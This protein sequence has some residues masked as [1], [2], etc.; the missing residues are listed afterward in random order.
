M[1]ATVSICSCVMAQAHAGEALPSQERVNSAYFFTIDGSFLKLR[2][3]D[4][5]LAADWKLSQTEGSSVLPPC[6]KTPVYAEP[7]CDLVFD[8]LQAGNGKLYGVF[9]TKAK[10]DD[11]GS[12]EYQVLV[13]QLPE[14]K[15][16]GSVPIPQAQ[17]EWPSLLL[18]PDGQRF[19]LN[20]RDR[21]AEKSATEPTVVSI[22]DVYGS[23]TLTK[24]S[25]MRQEV[26]T[27]VKRVAGGTLVHGFNLSVALLY[28]SYFSSDGST[29]FNGLRATKILGSS[30][31]ARNVN[32]LEKLSAEQREQLKPF[33]TIEPGTK[34]PYFN[35]GAADSA[36]G[37]TGVAV[38]NAAR[39]EAA[40]WTVDLVTSQVSPIVIAPWGVARLTPD[41]TV[42]VIQ[43]SE[44]QTSGGGNVPGTLLGA[45]FWLYD[46]ASG[47]KVGEF[48]DP[49]LAGPFS[50]NRLLCFSSDGKRFFYAVND[51]IHVVSLPD[52]QAIRVIRTDLPNLPKAMSVLANQ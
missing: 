47:Q 11:E 14:M 38:A 42:L 18:T 35:Y 7:G 36:A 17:A 51:S 1:L 52:G 41:A 6:Q 39:T 22:V 33:Q 29:I 28:N 19:F 12:R 44:V 31:E 25:S 48:S 2:T 4:G 26:A 37:K 32:P 5:R 23:S 13:F 49:A 16:V 40:Y 27:K 20:Y 9:P 34:M 30:M 15:V 46:V 45:K 8:R 24:A 21:A 43:Q 3:D 50:S 10:P